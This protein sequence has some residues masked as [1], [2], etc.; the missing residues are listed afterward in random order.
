MK[1]KT[2]FKDKFIRKNN[3]NPLSSFFEIIFREK[4][5]TKEDDIENHIF[6]ELDPDGSW[7][8]FI[9][10]TESTSTTKSGNDGNTIALKCTRSGILSCNAKTV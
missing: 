1:S 7:A 3:N 4:I 5:S 6:K 8:F 9:L 10:Y 2:F